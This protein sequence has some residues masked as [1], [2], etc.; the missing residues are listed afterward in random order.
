MKIRYG[1]KNLKYAVGYPDTSGAMTYGAYK[2]MKGAK[3]MALTQV[4]E[5]VIEYADDIEWFIAALNSGYDGNVV[6][7]E[8]PESFLIDILGYVKDSNGVLFED[9]DVQPKEFALAGEFKNAGDATVTGKRFCFFRCIASRPNVEG[10]TKQN[11]ITVAHDTLN[12]K[13]MARIS[14]G[15]VKATADSNATGYSSWFNAVVTRTGA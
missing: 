10:E 7:E 14:D 11:N 13:A 5:N 3:S 1:L 8:V 6:L 9:A 4:G 12:I 15:M 2:D